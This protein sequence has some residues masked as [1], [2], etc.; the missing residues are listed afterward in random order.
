MNTSQESLIAGFDPTPA[1]RDSTSADRGRETFID[2][3]HRC[4]VSDVPLYE[5]F[6]KI[7][8]RRVPADSD[9]R[10]ARL[11]STGFVMRDDADIDVYTQRVAGRH[12]GKFQWLYTNLFQRY[13]AIFT[14]PIALVVWG[15]GCGLDLI[16]L[17]DQA[18]KEGNPN[19]WLVVKSITLVDIS[20]AA[21]DR[22]RD[23]AMLL[24]PTAEVRTVNVDLKNQEQVLRSVKL[25]ALFPYTVRVHLISNVLDLFEDVKPFADSTIRLSARMLVRPDE[26]P[27]TVYN[28]MFIAFSP[29]YKGGGVRRNM[30][31]FRACWGPAADDLNFVGEAPLNCEY[32][33]FSINSLRNSVAYK[34]FASGNKLLRRMVHRLPGIIDDLSAIQLMRRLCQLTLAEVPFGDQYEFIE[35]FA[36]ETL[37]RKQAD[38]KPEKVSHKGVF[39]VAGIG[40]RRKPFVVLLEHKPKG[41]VVASAAEHVLRRM[42]EHVC[43]PAVKTALDRID[44]E[45]ARSRNDRKSGGVKDAGRDANRA[46]DDS[47]FVTLRKPLLRHVLFASWDGE[48]KKLMTSAFTPV[49]EAS[50]Y[51]DTA[52]DVDYSKHFVIVPGDVEKLPPLSIEQKRIAESRRQLCKVKG[53]P[54]VGKTVTM[55]WHAIKAVQHTHLPVLILC[56][57]VSLISFNERRLVASYLADHPDEDGLDRS[58]FRFKTI[59]AFL[60]DYQKRRGSCVLRK[61]GQCLARCKRLKVLSFPRARVQTAEDR[62]REAEIMRFFDC[63]TCRRGADYREVC[64]RIGCKGLCAD[65]LRQRH[66]MTQDFMTESCRKC[67][68]EIV[69]G[70]RRRDRGRSWEEELGAVLIDETQI[71]DP[72]YVKS[73]YNLTAVGNPW[74]EF[75][76]FCDAQQAFRHNTLEQD[77]KTKKWNVRVPDTGFGY[78]EVLKENHRMKS[79]AL[80]EACR[81]VQG[82]LKGRDEELALYDWTK[83]DEGGGSGV[84][85]FAIRSVEKVTFEMLEKEVAHLH[86]ACGA[87]SVTVICEEQGLARTF[88][89]PARE[90]D[91]IVTHLA[92]ETY[93]EEKKLREEFYEHP[94]CNHL[95]SVDCAQGQ[96]F[97][98]VVFVLSSNREQFDEGVLEQVFTALSRSGRFL[99]VYDASS[100]HWLHGLMKGRV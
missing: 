13:R 63:G 99:R 92:K 2:D 42:V 29:D 90:K 55:L 72:D 41:S 24:F 54:G 64:K 67:K 14:S 31:R 7:A 85:A 93:A 65:E 52:A 89:S 44:S 62:K 1:Q 16:A 43:D 27:M 9:V 50:D 79:R 96:S 48:S 95:T 34:T 3:F 4:L 81:I 51:D 68:S 58:L 76:L 66:V 56:K 73:V 37:E 59:D 53:G 15:C 6:T 26:R 22:A 80:I 25:G 39:F 70:L 91:W 87:E 40:M 33:A 11:R 20:P 12:C 45:K 28:E 77:V 46:E 60:C 30:E 35:T 78:F 18:M 47:V 36:F 86:D 82:K 38:S 88:S 69:R 10:Y 97:E 5:A 32:A 71:A 8:N 17:Y 57:T 19:F 23:I 98:A 94:G 75:Y 21:L 61:C 83:L 100:R 84:G 49:E 74:R